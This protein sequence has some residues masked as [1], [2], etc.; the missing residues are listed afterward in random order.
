MYCIFK[1]ITLVNRCL[2]IPKDRPRRLNNQGLYAD[3][4]NVTKSVECFK[5]KCLPEKDQ[6]EKCC[7]PHIWWTCM[8]IK[9][10]Q[11]KWTAIILL[12]IDE[13]FYDLCTKKIMLFLFYNSTR[14]PCS[15]WVSYVAY[16]LFDAKLL[17]SSVFDFMHSS[18]LTY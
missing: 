14:M 5:R 7:E 6:P 9:A 12:Y 16:I 10:H 11:K 18:A 1:I 2:V 4:Q 17:L 15:R 13:N 3:I 8:N